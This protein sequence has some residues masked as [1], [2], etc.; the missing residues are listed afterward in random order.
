ME[1]CDCGRDRA[2][3]QRLRRVYAAWRAMEEVKARMA[4]PRGII[5]ITGI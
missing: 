3:H 1:G 2:M 5:R 4:D